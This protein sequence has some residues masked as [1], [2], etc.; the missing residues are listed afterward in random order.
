M[1]SEKSLSDMENQGSKGETG[2]GSSLVSLHGTLASKAQAFSWPLVG[3]VGGQA[4]QRRSALFVEIVS[5][6]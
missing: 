3:R 6:Y 1:R 5:T 4:A 2:R